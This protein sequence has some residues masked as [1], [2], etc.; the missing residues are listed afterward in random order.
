MPG[1][2]EQRDFPAVTGTSQLSPYLNIGVLSIRQC[3]QALFRE[4]EGHLNFQYDSQ[5]T[6]LDELLWREFYL[7]LLFD[8]PRLS[9]HLPFQMHTQQLSWRDDA[10][11]LHAWQTGQTGIPIVDAGMRQMLTTGWMHNRVRMIT[12]MFLCKNLLLDWRLG[13]C[14][15]MQHLIDGDLAANNGGWQWCA[16]TGT[17]AV[18]I[19]VF[20]IQSVSRANLIPM[21]IISGG[22]CL[23]WR[24]WMPKPFMTL[25]RFNQRS[26]LITHNRLLT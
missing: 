25:M 13:E 10:A 11:Q 7:Q 19:S 2:K 1:Y 12:A 6:W 8:H 20:L 21:E 18:H 15:F 5:Q 4:Q 3:L 23:N 22:G 14:W 26:S 24:I 9:K 17:D 16:S